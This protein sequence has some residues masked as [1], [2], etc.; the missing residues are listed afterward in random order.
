M[1]FFIEYGT[2]TVGAVHSV[3]SPDLGITIEREMTRSAADRPI[4]ERAQSEHGWHKS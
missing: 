4:G 2:N 3:S 1:L